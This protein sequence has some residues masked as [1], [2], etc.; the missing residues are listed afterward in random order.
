MLELQA[1]C[2][3]AREAVELLAKIKAVTTQATPFACDLQ[4][5]SDRLLVSAV[6]SRPQTAE[7]CRW[8]SHKARAQTR[9]GASFLSFSLS[10]GLSFLTQFAHFCATQ[11]ALISHLDKDGNG[12]VTSRE[13]SELMKKHEAFRTLEHMFSEMDWKLLSHI[14]SENGVSSQNQEQDKSQL[15]KRKHN[16]IPW[17]LYIHKHAVAC[18]FQRSSD[19][20]LVA[21]G[22]Q[23]GS[24]V[25]IRDRRSRDHQRSVSTQDQSKNNRRKQKRTI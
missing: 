14:L 21:T 17:S 13:F 16:M 5:H 6:F 22:H 2:D 20:L 12:H 19:R 1:L 7:E 15:Y 25:A 10:F 4:V 18:A 9:D 3:P 23:H 8:R 24:A 11:A